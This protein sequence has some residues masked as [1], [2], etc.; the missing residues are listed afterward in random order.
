MVKKSRFLMMLLPISSAAFLTFLLYLILRAPQLNNTYLYELLMKRGPIQWATMFL[1]FWTASILAWKMFFTVR[2]NG[3]WDHVPFSDLDTKILRAEAGAYIERI[4]TGVAQ[5]KN[6]LLGKRLVIGLENF[7]AHGKIQEAVDVLSVQSDID[8]RE[9]DN[10][11]TMIKVFLASIPILGFIGTVYGIGS[12]VGGFG[13]TLDDA[14]D[15]EA[16]KNSLGGVTS[17]LSIAFDTTLLALVMSI[18]LMIPLG[19]V[20]QFEEKSLSEID[21]YV[22]NKFVNI[23]QEEEDNEGGPAGAVREA[24][25]Q[26]LGT[27]QK[28]LGTITEKLP[29]V[30]RQEGGGQN[31]VEMQS[32]MSQIQGLHRE[33]ADML[34]QTSTAISGHGAKMQEILEANTDFLNNWGQQ[35]TEHLKESQGAIVQSESKVAEQLDISSKALT[36]ETDRVVNVYKE[37]G[38]EF[39]TEL[40]KFFEK[41]IGDTQR[42]MAEHINEEQSRIET[43]MSRQEGATASFSKATQVAMDGLAESTTR[44]QGKEVELLEHFERKAQENID[45]M[46]QAFKVL[47]EKQSDLVN[48]TNVMKEEARRQTEVC[49]QLIP[50]LATTAERQLIETRQKLERDS[51]SFQQ[52]M[53]ERHSTL[54]QKMQEQSRQQSEILKDFHQSQKTEH[55]SLDRL[56]D[57]WGAIASTLDEAATDETGKKRKWWQ[58]S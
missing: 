30:I 36:S 27:V 53:M 9:S 10:S 32:I 46:S 41:S 48:S 47:M 39:V 7:R 55:Q 4:H 14:G 57:R 49:Q 42:K 19:S 12:A 2:E 5:I 24:V 33:Q 38:A 51:E 44:W 29:P 25:Q 52:E 26:S 37:M 28:Q 11:Y 20:Q 16:I 34:A 45:V 50:A 3:C 23:L 31:A 18:L 58:W 1:S 56:T 40:T 15:V 17:G 35:F 8:S 6:S 21:D 13:S 54:L 22:N 43:L